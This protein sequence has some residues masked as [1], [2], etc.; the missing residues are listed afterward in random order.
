MADP[1]ENGQPTEPN[2][3]ELGQDELLTFLLEK[4]LIL[5]EYYTEHQ[6]AAG[7]FVYKFTPL[8]MNSEIDATVGALGFDQSNDLLKNLY[9]LLCQLGLVNAA[10]R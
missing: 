9:E 2:I 6:E 8:I 10:S 5:P 3:S 4:G 1:Y 7:S